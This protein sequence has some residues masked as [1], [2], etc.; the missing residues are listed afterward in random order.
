MRRYEAVSE[1]KGTLP[2]KVH[3]ENES[4]YI[5]VD[6]KVIK[7]QTK[8]R[9]YFGLLP[10]DFPIWILPREPHLLFHTKGFSNL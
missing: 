4:T 5:F 2:T 10:R 8:N 1:G 3:I 7:K 6:L 9:L